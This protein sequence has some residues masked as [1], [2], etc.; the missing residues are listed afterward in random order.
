MRVENTVGKVGFRLSPDE[1]LRVATLLMQLSKELINKKRGL[2][3]Q[4]E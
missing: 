2:W 1:A 3:Q 4:E